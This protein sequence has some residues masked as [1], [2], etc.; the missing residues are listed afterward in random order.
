M[1]EFTFIVVFQD[2][3]SNIQTVM[4]ETETD[5]RRAI[6]HFYMEGGFPIR[7]IRLPQFK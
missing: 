5:A 2:H 6:I 3:T 1:K 7:S 4:A